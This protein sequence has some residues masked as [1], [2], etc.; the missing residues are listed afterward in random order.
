MSAA[1]WL[2]SGV[3][4]LASVRV[5]GFGVG[6]ALLCRR[7]RGGGLAAHDGLPETVTVTIHGQDM[8]VMGQAVEQC[9]GEP[10]GAENRCPVFEWQVGGDA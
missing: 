10:L 7:R 9:A 5:D 4:D 2:G 1:A 3:D 6:V 8:N